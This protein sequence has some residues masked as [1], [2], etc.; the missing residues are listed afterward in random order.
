MH[1]QVACG[2]SSLLHCQSE[3]SVLDDLPCLCRRP[4]PPP[5]RRPVVVAAAPACLAARRN[6]I[7]GI[8]LQI[9]RELVFFST[10]VPL[11]LMKFRLQDYADRGFQFLQ[12]QVDKA[13]GYRARGAQAIELEELK[14]RKLLNRILRRPTCL[15]L[16]TYRAAKSLIKLISHYLDFLCPFLS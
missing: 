9:G 15:E 8:P 10:L 11:N 3:T 4:L 7:C 13:H 5:R 1:M 2:R 6:K 14:F 16:I 12:G